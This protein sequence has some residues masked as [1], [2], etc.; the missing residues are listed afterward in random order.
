[1]AE[2]LP[3]QYFVKV[4]WRCLRG[5][6]KS[7][8]ALRGLGDRKHEQ[9]IPG[10]HGSA[11]PGSS[12]SIQLQPVPTSSLP[13]LSHP[14]QVVSDKWLGCEAVLPVSFRHLILPEKYA[15]PTE[16]LDLQPLPISALR[17]YSWAGHCESRGI[18]AGAASQ[19]PCSRAR[20]VADD[21]QSA[22]HV[23][24]QSMPGNSWA[25]QTITCWFST[26]DRFLY[27]S[28]I[29]LLQ[30]PRVREAVHS[31]HALQP[32]PDPGEPALQARQQHAGLRQGRLQQ[33]SDGDGTAAS[34]SSSAG[35]ALP[36]SLFP[37][38]TTFCALLLNKKQVFTA[39]YNT[40]DNA[41]VAAPTGSGKTICAEFALLRV[42]QRAAEGKCTAR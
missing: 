41:L 42:I 25:A 14:P 4:G 31:L 22:L 36:C 30:E 27:P 32:H 12:S 11:L 38:P 29:L 23:H 9:V 8:A 28:R 37:V 24:L 3:P 34:N 19:Q 20:E 18:A 10:S 21:A 39:L 16:L 5:P 26:A 1:M 7:L 40:D 17:C 2:P 33:G 6:G 15:P 35:H 13:C